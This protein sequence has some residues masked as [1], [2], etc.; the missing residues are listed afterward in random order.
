MGRDIHTIVRM[1]VV[2]LPT[3]MDVFNLDFRHPC[4]LKPASNF[5]T[6]YF[7]LDFLSAVAIDAPLF[8]K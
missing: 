6:R 4:R 5:A 1:H 8:N 3:N 7:N 2:V